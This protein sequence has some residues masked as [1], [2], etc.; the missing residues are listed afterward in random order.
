M[1]FRRSLTVGEF[2]ASY[3]PGYTLIA[4]QIRRFCADLAVPSVLFLAAFFLPVGESVSADH[5][6]QMTAEVITDDLLA[7]RMVQHTVDGTDITSR[8]STEA[9]VP[10]PTI[11]V[12]EGD[13]VVITIRNG[14]TMRPDQQ[15]SIHTH[16]VHYKILSDGTLKVINKVEDEGAYP[17]GFYTYLWDVA[18]GTAGTWPYHDHNFETHNGSEHRGLFGAVIVNPASGSVAASVGGRIRSVSVDSI[19]KDYILFLGDDA[20]WGMEIDGASKEQ[21]PRWTNPVLSARH[22][23]NVR[24]HLIAMGTDLHQFRLKGYRWVDPGTHNLID[25]AAIG[26]L[27]NHVFTIKSSHSADYLDRNFSNR[28]MGMRGDFNVTQ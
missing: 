28:L 17:V 5:R 20:F 7:Y 24:F 1:K 27:E 11:V 12:S 3:N 4:P 18:P 23:D 19:K 10:G 16:G 6:I 15:V 25:R 8:Y 22:G 13:K 2:C 14:I 9:T 21:T 26:P